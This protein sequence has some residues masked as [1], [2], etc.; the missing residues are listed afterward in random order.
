MLKVNGFVMDIRDTPR[1][2]QEI[3]FEARLDPVY[4]SD[5]H[6]EG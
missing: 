2:A 3:A 4:P 1:E 6:G 5:R